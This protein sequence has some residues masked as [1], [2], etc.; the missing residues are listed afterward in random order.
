MD[1]MFDRFDTWRRENEA[2]H[3]LSKAAAE[4][5]YMMY[6]YPL[7]TLSDVISRDNIDGNVFIELVETTGS[8]IKE[9]T[10]WKKTEIYQIESVLF[11]HQ[12]MNKDEFEKN[13]DYVLMNDALPNSIKGC[14]RDRMVSFDIVTILARI[15]HGLSNLEF[16]EQMVNMVE[17]LFE[18]N[19]KNKTNDANKDLAYFGDDLIQK[20]YALIAECLIWNA[21]LD[22]VNVAGAACRRYDWKC[23]NCGNRNFCAMIDGQRSTDLSIC[24]LCGAS[25]RYSIILNLRNYNTFVTVHQVI[26]ED[27]AIKVEDDIDAF[28]QTAIRDHKFNVLCLNESRNTQCP[29]MIRLCKCLIQHKRWLYTVG[30]TPKKEYGQND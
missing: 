20:V 25:H 2:D 8:F 10:G 14:I 6:H 24:R 13:L 17:E 11:E 18:I 15:R 26:E 3:L 22:T 1:I 9:E 5:A 21:D 29:A 12:C 4:I 28:I 23:F 19:E 30:G 7:D 16:N 27:T